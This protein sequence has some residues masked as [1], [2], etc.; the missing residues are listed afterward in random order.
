[1]KFQ[2]NDDKQ[3]SDAKENTSNNSTILIAENKV[4]EFDEF[5]LMFFI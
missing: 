3:D 4:I 2:A 1:L 5:L